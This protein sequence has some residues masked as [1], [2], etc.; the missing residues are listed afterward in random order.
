MTRAYW[1]DQITHYCQYF[2]L[3]RILFTSNCT[4]FC[5]A[6]ITCLHF[7]LCSDDV[8]LPYMYARFVILESQNLTKLTVSY[9][10]CWVCKCPVNPQINALQSRCVGCSYLAWTHSVNMCCGWLHSFFVVSSILMVICSYTLYLLC[11]F[12]THQ[13]WMVKL[14]SVLAAT[15]QQACKMQHSQQKMIGLASLVWTQSFC[16]GFC[17]VLDKTSQAARHNPR[18]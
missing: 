9:M 2:I 1:S 10:I 16:P 14:Y 13:W 4:P 5:K 8:K 12:V 15:G 6:T 18:W 17:A 3:K 11:N 7:K